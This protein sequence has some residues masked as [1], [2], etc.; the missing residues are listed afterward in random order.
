VIVAQTQSPP[1]APRNAH[2]DESVLQNAYRE[3]LV[4]L[5]RFLNLDAE[6]S[7]PRKNGYKRLLIELDA[8]IGALSREEYLPLHWIDIRNELEQMKPRETAENT[9]QFMSIENNTLDYDAFVALAGKKGEQEDPDRLLQN[10]LVPTGVVFYKPGLFDNKIIL[11]QAWA[12]R[13]VY[14]LFDRSEDGFYYEI[15][16]KEGRFNG[17]L[18][19]RCWSQYGSAEREWFLSFMLA[20]DMCFEITP[21]HSHKTPWDEREF[22]ALEMLRDNRPEGFSLQEE[23]WARYENKHTLHLIFRYPF[24]HSGVIQRFIARTYRFAEVRNIYKKGVL[25]RVGNEPILVEARLE[26]DH[27]YRGEIRVTVAYSGIHALFRVQ[28]AFNNI[29]SQ[30]E[31]EVEQWVM[32]DNKSPVRLSEL[33]EKR[34]E[35]QMVATDG[36]TIV[37]T[38]DYLVFIKPAEEKPAP[39]WEPEEPPIVEEEAP[40]KSET[41]EK[42]VEMIDQIK[43][44]ISQ[45]KL[46][47]AL[48]LLQQHYPSDEVIALQQDFNRLKQDEI[49]GIL[50][51]SDANVIRARITKRLLDWLAELHKKITSPDPQPTFNLGNKKTTMRILLSILVVTALIG[52]FCLER[53]GKIDIFKVLSIVVD[54]PKAEGD[55]PSS[56]ISD[57]QTYVT[58]IGS[59]FINQRKATSDDVSEVG[60]RGNNIVN[61]VSLS[62]NQFTL[63]NV[64]IPSDKR[65]EIAITF[66]DNR[67]ESRVFNIGL[68]DAHGRVDIG[69]LRI[70]Y[71]DLEDELRRKKT[72]IVIQNNNIIQNSNNQNSTGSGNQEIQQ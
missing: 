45:G 61:P 46:E 50:S 13:T 71:Q 57:E 25:L 19:N 11:N 69:E 21:E 64:P 56:S 43:N 5:S 24:L 38:A 32:P 47:E 33:L 60:V 68:P 4:Y 53:S 8:A 41:L 51:Y 63:R 39:L 29:H 6:Q 35:K 37:D 10:W 62:G 66:M 27:I 31:E 72:V 23:N 16:D 26:E 44:K 36:K 49:A 3:Q 2:P 48:K 34:G 70:T 1:D 28:Q 15:K 54:P 52:F 17:E 40:V 59:V 67:Q 55:S 58:V 20:A 42:P 14:A 12:I 9:A 30:N 7:E 18:L 22:I 65:L